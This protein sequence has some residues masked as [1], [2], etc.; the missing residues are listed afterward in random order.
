[1]IGITAVASVQNIQKQNQYI[2]IQ[3][4]GYLYRFELVGLFRFGMPFKIRYSGASNSEHLN[5]KYIQ[6]LNVLKFGFR[7]SGFGMVRT[8]RKP[9]I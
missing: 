1:M 5:T 6:I 3:D 9:N 8:I 7:M 4:G 2:E